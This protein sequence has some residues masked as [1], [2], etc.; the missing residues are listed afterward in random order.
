MAHPKIK[1]TITFTDQYGEH[2]NLS[3]RQILEI[4]EL[5]YKWLKDYTWSIDPDYD[6]KTERC[7]YYKTIYRKLNVKQR[8]QFREIK[9]EVKS[10]YEKQDFEKR[11][12]EIKQKEYASLKLSDNELVELQ[13]IL[14]KIQW[15]TS[16]K[17]SYKVEDYTINHRRN[18]YLKIAH[19]K[20]K[21]FLNQ[22]QLKE[23]Y[24][25][26]QL[27][28]DWIKKGQIELIVNMN[29]SLNLT[30]EQ[31]EL[32]YNY[33]ENK[34]SKDSKGEILSEFEEWKL[35]KSFKKSIL[36]EQQFKK[37]LEWQ[38]HNEKLRISY[39]DDENK[40]KIQKIKE[41]ESY[42]DYLIKHYLPVL[43]NWRETIEKDIP[44]NIKLELEILRNTY[45]NDLKK[46]LLEHLKAHKRHTRDYVPKGKILIKL[47]FKQRALIPSVYCLNKKQ[48][49]IINN[50]SKN[51]IKLID[52]KQI[53]LKDLYIK[54]HN[55][56]IDNYEEY[57]GTYGASIKVIRNNEPNTNIQLINTLLLHPQLSKNLEF[58]DSI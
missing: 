51:L 20:L 55:F 48:K 49:T 15:E 43:C 14:Q 58:A 4:D 21:T 50:L 19:E 46:R 37:Y 32:I 24:R 23:F 35:E 30:N 16:D 8:S 28:E 17:S 52:N 10:N 3:K 27:N 56:H 22:E 7:R 54:K 40:G 6:E 34:T 2:L 31:A 9:Q 29:E 12:F 38:E 26:D 41:I 1:N 5:T 45:Q 39:F 33:R 42:L 36:D 13:E 53:E 44:N 57:G 47:E 25:V 18:L 11:R